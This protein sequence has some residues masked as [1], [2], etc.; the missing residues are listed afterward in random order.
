MNVAPVQIK[1]GIFRVVLFIATV[2]ALAVWRGHW[3]AT[4]EGLDHRSG[5]WL[6][7]FGLKAGVESVGSVFAMFYWLVA[8]TYRPVAVEPGVTDGARPDWSKVAILYLCCD[9]VQEAA[10]ETLAQFCTQT[11]A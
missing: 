10:L 7:V 1:P 6:W 5:F 8:L 9:D 11:P 3:F 4:L 2:M